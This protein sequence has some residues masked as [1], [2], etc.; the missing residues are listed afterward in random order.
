MTRPREPRLEFPKVLDCT[1]ADVIFR[2]IEMMEFQRWKDPKLVFT[3]RVIR[4]DQYS[5]MQIQMFV[6]CKAW[7]ILPASSKLFK[8]SKIAG[9]TRGFTKNKFLGSIFRCQLKVAGE[10]TIIQT[11]TQKLTGTE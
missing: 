2:K 5:G 1:T 8:I 4:P 6:R 10:V 7:E 9:C 11:I 3:G